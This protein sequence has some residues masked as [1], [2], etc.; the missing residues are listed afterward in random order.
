MDIQH[1]MALDYAR[2]QLRRSLVF[3]HTRRS[4]PWSASVGSEGSLDVPL[5]PKRHCPANTTQYYTTMVIMV[6]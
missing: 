4:A 2:A 6:S 5:G 3:V 1:S